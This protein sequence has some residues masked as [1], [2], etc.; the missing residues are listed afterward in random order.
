MGGCGDL[1]AAERLPRRQQRSQ[2]GDWTS[3][4]PVRGLPDNLEPNFNPMLVSSRRLLVLMSFE[5]GY[6]EVDSKPPSGTQAPQHLSDV[7]RVF[8]LLCRAVT[9]GCGISRL[10]G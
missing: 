10:L 5:G 4:L 9:G 8:V 1:A 7:V 2:T 3:C 6:L